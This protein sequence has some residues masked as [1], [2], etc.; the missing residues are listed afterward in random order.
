MSLP[1]LSPIPNNAAVAPIAI[2]H[3]NAGP[4]VVQRVRPAQRRGLR[5]A[6]VPRAPGRQPRHRNW[7]GVT[8]GLRAQDHPMFWGP[9]LVATGQ[10][11]AF[12]GQYERGDAQ[13]TLHNNGIY[14]FQHPMTFSGVRTNIMPGSN[15]HWEPMVGTWVQGQ[16]YARDNS[17]I[18]QPGSEIGD[19]HELPPNDPEYEAN[20]IHPV[21]LELMPW[22][23]E[24]GVQP[25]GQG[26]RS[27]LDAVRVDLDAGMCMREISERHWGQY[28]RYHRSFNSYLDLHPRHRTQ[29]TKSHVFIGDFGV[30]KTHA[31]IQEAGPDA[32]WV[33]V[34][35]GGRVWF[36][37][38]SNQTVVVFDE[39]EGWVK[40]S[41][42]ARILDSSPY[43]VEVK[44]GS[45]EFVATDV[46]IL[47]NKK[48][49]DWWPRIGLGPI[50]RRLM[51]REECTV[52]VFSK[53][54]SSE[55]GWPP[56]RTPYDIP[57][58]EI[59]DARREAEAERDQD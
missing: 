16:N 44:G 43:R 4:G 9:D 41:T 59:M 5:R 18:G 36:C 29:Q 11:T 47:S 54:P 3:G 6:G 39:F 58:N 20:F 23:Y 50:W 8:H 30:G 38:Y 52:E 42:M 21:T 27:D 10:L 28:V 1:P 57:S 46:Y 26:H 17:G 25:Q 24:G 37:G 32:H 34:P 31:C 14:R 2:V 12:F 56:I 40:R 13:M 35:D 53:D 15:T 7:M 49:E 55:S 22:Q 19:H 48:P 33:P 45:I 51:A